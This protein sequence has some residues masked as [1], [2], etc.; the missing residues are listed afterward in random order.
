MNK[1]VNDKAIVVIL[2]SKFIVFSL[3]IANLN[4]I[5]ST[6][7]PTESSVECSNG[8]VAGTC[9]RVHCVPE[10]GNQVQSGSLQEL[11]DWSVTMTTHRLSPSTGS[12]GRAG[13]L[14]LIP[15]S[16][17]AAPHFVTHQKHLITTHFVSKSLFET[18]LINY[19]TL[20]N[21]PL[22]SNNSFLEKRP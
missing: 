14:L 11:M 6:M 18:K 7:M 4:I 20:H 16:A 13:T 9:W 8:L 19:N 17:T 10:R 15:L 3:S 21:F 22:K 1:E 5:L 12:H 2:I